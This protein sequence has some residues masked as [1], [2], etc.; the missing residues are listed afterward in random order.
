MEKLH[1]YPI[2]DPLLLNMFGLKDSKIVPY[3][4]YY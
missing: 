4:V 3:N 2:L 1:K